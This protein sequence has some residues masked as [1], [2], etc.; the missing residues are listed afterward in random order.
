MAQSLGL[1][2]NVAVAA[3]GAGVGGV[4]FL[5]AG[6]SGDNGLIG[7]AGSGHFTHI[8]ATALGADVGIVADFGAGGS[9]GI[10]QFVGV[11]QSGNDLVVE[12]VANLTV[13]NGVAISGAGSFADN[14]AVAQVAL[15]QHIAVAASAGIL[16]ILVLGFPNHMVVADMLGANDQTAAGNCTQIIDLGQRGGDRIEAEQS[17]ASAVGGE[18]HDDGAG[19]GVIA[20]SHGRAVGIAVNTQVLVGGNVGSHT[21]LHI[22][23]GDVVHVSGVDVQLAIGS[24]G[25]GVNT[26]VF[27]AVHAVDDEQ[28]FQLTGFQIDFVQSAAASQFQSIHIAVAVAAGGVVGNILIQTVAAQSQHAIIDRIIGH[29]ADSEVIIVVILVS[30]VAGDHFGVVFQDLHIG[31]ANIGALESVRLGGV[32]QAVLC[33]I[34]ID[35]A[36]GADN[37]GHLGVA[38]SVG[39]EFHFAVGTVDLGEAA[40]DLV[41]GDEVVILAVDQNG[42]AV[43]SGIDT[44]G[45]DQSD[46]GGAVGNGGHN[47]VFIHS[48]HRL[49][50]RGP[51]HFQIQT[52]GSLEDIQRHGV[53]DGQFIALAGNGQAGQ[54]RGNFGIRFRED[55]QAGDLRA[56]RTDGA[57]IVSGHFFQID[58][59]Q[60]A[61][62]AGATEQA[63]PVNVTGVEV[64][65]HGSQHIGGHAGIHNHLIGAIDRIQSVELGVLIGGFPGDGVE[66]VL[67]GGH[68]VD[69]AVGV[70]GQAHDHGIHGQAF[71]QLTVG[72][73]HIVQVGSGV[74]GTGHGIHGA[75]SV[76]KCHII[77]K[78]EAVAH[79]DAAGH[80]PGSGIDGQEL[81]VGGPVFRIEAIGVDHAIHIL[82][83]VEGHVSAIVVNIADAFIFGGGIVQLGPVEAVAVAQVADQ[84]AE[85]VIGAILDGNREG[86]IVPGFIAGLIGVD[87]GGIDGSGAHAGA[88][89]SAVL[90]HISH[91]GIGG[92]PLGNGA[93]GGVGRIYIHGGSGGRA[94]QNHNILCL[95]VFYRNVG[96]GFN[97]FGDHE[98]AGI[99][100]QAAVGGIAQ[101]YDVGA[102]AG[103]I[104]DPIQAGGF[105]VEPQNGVIVV[106]ITHGLY[107]IV[108][109]DAGIHY[110]VSV[111]GVGGVARGCQRHDAA[112]AAAI[113]VRLHQVQLVEDAVIADGI[114]QAFGGAGQ[115][116][117]VIISGSHFHQ[118]AGAH[119]QRIQRRL[120]G[121]IAVIQNIHDTAGVVV[122]HIRRDQA[123]IG[124]A[125][126]AVL[127]GSGIVPV[128]LAHFVVAVNITGVAVVIGGDEVNGRGSH[129]FFLA[130]VQVDFQPGAEIAGAVVVL[131]GIHAAGDIHNSHIAGS[132]EAVA[133]SGDDSA[134]FRDGGHDA[135]FIYHR[136][137]LI[138][139]APGQDTNFLGSVP[140]QGV[141]NQGMGLADTQDHLLLAHSH[142]GDLG[143]LR[144]TVAIV[145]QGD[146][147]HELLIEVHG[148]SGTGPGGGVDG[149]QLAGIAIVV[150]PVNDAVSFA[151]GHRLR[152]VG[153]GGGAVGVVDGDSIAVSIRHSGQ[154]ALAVIQIHGVQA[155]VVIFGAVQGAIDEGHGPGY[156]V[157]AT[158]VIQ[159]SGVAGEQIH[160]VQAVGV[161]IL[162]GGSQIHGAGGIVERH[163]DDIQADIGDQLAAPD[164]GNHVNQIA[165]GIHAEDQ[166]VHIFRGGQSPVFIHIAGDHGGLSGQ[167]VD[168]IPAEHSIPA[169]V[170]IQVLIVH[171]V[172]VQSGFIH[173]RIVVG[174]GIGQRVGSF[175]AAIVADGH[176]E[177][178]AQVGDIN[179][180]GIGAVAIVDHIHIRVVFIDLGAAGAHGDHSSGMLFREGQG[181]VVAIFIGGLHDLAGIQ[182]RRGGVDV[183]GH[184]L[185]QNIGLGA[186]IFDDTGNR[187]IDH[188]AVLHIREIIE[189]IIGPGVN[190]GHN[191]AV[192]RDVHGLGFLPEIS[193]VQDIAF[194]VG[195]GQFQLRGVTHQGQV[196]LGDHI[197][198][199][200][201]VGRDNIVIGAVVYM[202]ITI[203]VIPQL[204]A[205]VGVHT[206]DPVI[207][208]SAQAGIQQV[209]VLVVGD[210]AVFAQ[211][212][213]LVIPEAGIEQRRLIP[214]AVEA[215]EGQAQGDFL[216][217]FQ[218]DVAFHIV[219]VGEVGVQPQL[220]FLGQLDG[221]GDLFAA[222]G[223]HGNGV[224]AEG[225]SGV[226]QSAVVLG[227]EI[228][229]IVV[230]HVLAQQA[231]AQIIGLLGSGEII[232]GEGE[233][234]LAFGVVLQLCLGAG[235]AFHGQVSFSGDGCQRI[236]QACALLTG[237]GFH[238]GNIVDDGHSGAHQQAVDHHTSFRVGRVGEGFLQ[239]LQHHSGDAGNLRRGHGSTAHQAVLTIVI[240]G[241]NIA[242][243]AGQ[244]GQQSQVRGS[245]PAGE[246]THLTAGAVE[247][248]GEIFGNIQGLDRG[249]GH[250]LAVFQGD[251][252]SGDA[253]I[254]F[255]AILIGD[256]S[257][258]AKGEDI[259]GNI[260]PDHDGNGA[261][262][263]RIG[264]LLTEGNGATADN[265]D[266]ALDDGV[267]VFVIEVGSFAQIGNDH[268][269]QLTCVRQGLQGDVGVLIEHFHGAHVEDLGAVGQAEVVGGNQVVVHRTDGHGVGISRGRGHRA[270]FDVIGQLH[271]GAPGGA[272]AAGAFVT[273][274]NIDDHI[275]IGD[276]LI[277]AVDFLNIGVG[278][279]CG[280]AQG[281]IDNVN[282]QDHTVLDGLDHV[283]HAGAARGA[284]HLHGDDL[285]IGRHAHN[286]SAFHLVGG[287]DAGNMG[288]VVA[289]T[290]G[291]A[292]IQVGRGIVEGEG[293]LCAVV[294]I[295]SGNFLAVKFFYLQ[296]IGIQHFLQPCDIPQGIGRVRSEGRMV[297]IQAGIQNGDGHAGAGVAQL[298]PNGCHIGHNAGGIGGGIDGIFSLASLI[299][300]AQE[301]ALDA[302][303][304]GNGFQIGK[305]GLHNDGVGQ[306]GELRNHIQFL[307]AQNILLDGSDHFALRGSHI[308]RDG[309]GDIVNGAVQVRGRLAC[310]GHEYNHFVH[311]LVVF[312][313]LLQRLNMLRQ[314]RVGQFHLGAVD[315][316][317]DPLAVFQGQFGVEL[318]VPQ[319]V[320]AQGLTGGNQKLIQPVGTGGSVF[321]LHNILNILAGNGNGVGRRRE[322]AEYQTEC[323]DQSKHLFAFHVFPP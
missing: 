201:A 49:V 206:Q 56:H 302:L 303:D 96:Q 12:F 193:V 249:I 148:S 203:L 224:A 57:Q 71:H 113:V 214:L 295:F 26:S 317:G 226:I 188:V 61:L 287:G 321:A 286:A 260:V 62:I 222:A 111:E 166:A 22:Q 20:H 80:G 282:A 228:V 299:D 241:V 21:G 131:I 172:S 136:N 314:L 275:A 84:V 234:E 268:I 216:F 318:L 247:A 66:L 195:V 210:I 108:A 221:D 254:A 213:A 140:G 308:L 124:I 118:L 157:L 15:V 54:L 70:H 196:D 191:A 230:H 55:H 105:G 13:V 258:H 42:A 25:H 194:G 5:L 141:G 278:E 294:Q 127:A 8:L 93:V 68:A 63:G 6:R 152:V 298:L 23:H 229:A 10:D 110:I 130:L 143:G 305:F 16:H 112:T 87:D 85:D 119:V 64:I 237:R 225:H 69:G 107:V 115:G 161:V 170:V 24:H 167:L 293:N 19:F 289:H 162:I 67:A 211:P 244:V 296:I 116:Q 218:I 150:S 171:L 95:N 257:R 128:A 146:H 290:V 99:L 261:G 280:A 187:Q 121:N 129:S 173:D 238:A 27:I 126:S 256:G 180:H 83:G 156:I 81:E 79:V 133:G 181:N 285:R 52:E 59:I 291:V 38:L 97:G 205:G 263:L 319:G 98:S 248:V 60:T 39:I 139:G 316:G 104:A 92:V 102:E 219:A 236:H 1:V 277:D 43:G 239:V 65:G 309:S 11:V 264:A 183:N 160:G 47:A 283:V 189:V 74:V 265:G 259:F 215:E 145:F 86:H 279:A 28:F 78:G 220:I 14:G 182:H 199:A 273:G 73:V 91:I 304:G 51:G 77:D 163:I 155:A 18:Q 297:Q 204:Q 32:E 274:G 243:N 320:Q 190:H 109:A 198:S 232:D 76:V 251:Q 125:Q 306:M 250:L 262:S 41:I 315:S 53:A 242:A 132:R 17:V 90:I 178:A 120:P 266:L 164:T 192:G 165:A 168:D 7:V 3:D 292:H 267:A 94:Y 235:A 82:S 88:H 253:G 184:I 310:Q 44:V 147:A 137:A 217:A 159:Q 103:Q 4:A 185:E 255:G 114:Q 200:V 312:F 149:D 123:G 186:F 144:Q 270:V 135:V 174:Q 29:V 153:T 212:H 106:V 154:L 323:Q 179:G 246:I 281:H 207:V 34:A 72:H 101:A 30:V 233:R 276:A 197:H 272:I 151:V 322:N 301:H 134:A 307:A 58:Q 2:S 117:I 46:G 177:I 288:A 311:G 37:S 158:I 169:I 122:S 75:G 231:G 313:C 50:R 176:G 208:G 89:H 45:G 202:G 209:A 284:E 300:G 9:D 142:L 252:N 33:V 100:D 223:R 245:A 269:L 48:C 36:I 227:Q 138:G 240:A 271:I 40:V 35:I 31:S 175:V